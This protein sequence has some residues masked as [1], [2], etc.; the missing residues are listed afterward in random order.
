MFKSPAPARAEMAKLFMDGG[1][2]I[3]IKS[4]RV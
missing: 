3:G 2:M 1:Q 4:E